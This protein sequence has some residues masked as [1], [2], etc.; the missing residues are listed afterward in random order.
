MNSKVRQIGKFI[1]VFGLTISLSGCFSRRPGDAAVSFMTSAIGLHFDEATKFVSQK[2]F[3]GRDPGLFFEKEKRNAKAMKLAGEYL[4]QHTRIRIIS[5]IDSGTTATVTL[6]RNG[7]AAKEVG[8]FL[9]AQ[10]LLGRHPSSVNDLEKAI[11]TSGDS[12]LKIVQENIDLT[13]VKEE[14]GWKVNF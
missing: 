11:G 1:T 4:E 6:E 9:F 5:E 7:P 13:L 12:T 8:K 3:G 14:G 10:Q 2:S